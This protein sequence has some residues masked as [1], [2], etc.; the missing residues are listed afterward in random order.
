MAELGPL[1]WAA[2]SRGGSVQHVCAGASHGIASAV[3]T[4]SGC[5]ATIDVEADADRFAAAD[6][7]RAIVA[8]AWD[9]FACSFH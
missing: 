3:P 6:A 8:A 7:K 1:S 4:A 5:D 2:V 9:W